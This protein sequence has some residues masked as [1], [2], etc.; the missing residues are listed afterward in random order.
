MYKRGGLWLC[1]E[2]RLAERLFDFGFGAVFDLA[3]SNLRRT[4]D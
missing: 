1:E 4:Y 3:R 2:E